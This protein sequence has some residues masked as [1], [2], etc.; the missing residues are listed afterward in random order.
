MG[1]LAFSQ[2]LALATG[3]LLSSGLWGLWPSA[4]ADVEALAPVPSAAPLHVGGL[5]GAGFFDLST[6]GGWAFSPVLSFGALILGG[7]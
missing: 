6:D 5:L 4:L 7:L 1:V 2:G 3:G